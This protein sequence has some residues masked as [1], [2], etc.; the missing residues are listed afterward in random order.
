MGVL[1]MPEDDGVMAVANAPVSAVVAGKL[2]TECGNMAVIRKDGCEF[3][4]A[5][6]AIGACG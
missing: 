1:E 5:C 2:C 6:G 3:C 4:T